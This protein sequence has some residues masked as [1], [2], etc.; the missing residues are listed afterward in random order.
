MTYRCPKRVVELARQVVFDIEA[1]P[2]APDGLVQTVGLGEAD[3]RIGD[4]IL[5]R[6]NAPLVKLAL[7]LGRR[8]LPVRIAGDDFLEGLE[9][10]I[11][12]IK[13]K[14]VRGL[15]IDLELMVRQSH[16]R[17]KLIP[18]DH[19]EERDAALSLHED[20][21]DKTGSL[22]ALAADAPDLETVQWRMTSMFNVEGPAILLS[23]KESMPAGSAFH[24]FTRQHARGRFPGPMGSRLITRFAPRLATV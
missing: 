6:Y 20:V 22:L 7:D 14:N 12:N 11:K 15:I 8:G 18:L 4:T 13:P 17:L 16:D 1:R 23:S 10:L 24:P 21:V 5:S 3:F 9:K 19:E 2:G